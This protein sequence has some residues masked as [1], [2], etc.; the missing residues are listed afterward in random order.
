MVQ[1]KQELKYERNRDK[2]FRGNCDTDARHISIS[3][4]LLTE[5]TIKILDTFTIPSM[6]H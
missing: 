4:A 5:S 2:T 6:W 1:C 3:R